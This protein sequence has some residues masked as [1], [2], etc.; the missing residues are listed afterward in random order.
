MS[1]SIR[2]ILDVAL[3]FFP[4][5]LV[6]SSSEA[7]ATLQKA[8]EQFLQRKISYD[9]MCT[10]S[11]KIAGTSQ[12]IERLNKILETTPDPI[13]VPDE[14]KNR[15]SKVNRRKNRAWTPYEDQRLLAGIYRNGIENWT[16]ISKFVGNAR[17]RS[18][19]SQRWY[20]GLDPAICKDQWTKEEEQKLVDLI[21][22][23]GDKSWTKISS[24]MGNRS[25]VQCRYKYRQLQK[26][27]AREGKILVPDVQ[28]QVPDEDNER[29]AARRL[30]RSAMND[31]MPKKQNNYFINQAPTLY[32]A[33]NVPISASTNQHQPTQVSPY[34]MYTQQLITQRP[35]IASSGSFVQNAGPLVQALQQPPSP[36]MVIQASHSHQSIPHLQVSQIPQISQ[37]DHHPQ[38]IQIIESSCPIHSPQQMQPQQPMHPPQLIQSSQI[39]QPPQLIQPLPPIQQPVQQIQYRLS[40]QNIQPQL[41]IIQQPQTQKVQFQQQMPQEINQMISFQPLQPQAINQKS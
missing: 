30:N 16:S 8:I 27:K 9:Q 1:N 32:I 10:I 33:Q 36:Q 15:S 7:F 20:R 31:L 22:T 34:R 39:I 13:P 4:P 41:Q 11:Q 26:E 29:P 35:Y 5:C 14:F 25:D 37:N 17:T 23:H 38:P 18:Q 40:P 19:C 6:N 21:N 2:A 12:P 24:K 3:T 28:Q